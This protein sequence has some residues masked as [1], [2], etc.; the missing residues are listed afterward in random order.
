MMHAYTVDRKSISGRG[1]AVSLAGPWSWPV[2]RPTGWRKC[3]SVRIGWSARNA[4]KCTGDRI[5]S[6]VY[7]VTHSA[8]ETHTRRCVSDASYTAVS[9]P[10]GSAIRR[11]TS[12]P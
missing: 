4:R 7:R 2:R 9:Q 6:G 12:G 11:A 5:V 8:R 3:T 10:G 1:S